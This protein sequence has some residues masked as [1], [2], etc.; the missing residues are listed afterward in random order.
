MSRSN[1]LICTKNPTNPRN[2]ANPQNKMSKSE[3]LSNKTPKKTQTQILLTKSWKGKNPNHTDCGYTKCE[4]WFTV[5]LQRA[6]L[7]CWLWLG[8][9]AR[10]LFSRL[11]FGCGGLGEFPVAWCLIGWESV[12]G[13]EVIA[14]A[15]GEIESGRGEWA[16]G[17]CVLW[18]G[19]ISFRVYKCI[20]I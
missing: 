8:L 6:S 3:N 1:K 15:G 16:A 17:E 9:S 4:A 14:W 10:I 7:I 12:W 19:R 11:G 2:F 5:D 13:R 20:Y 18:N